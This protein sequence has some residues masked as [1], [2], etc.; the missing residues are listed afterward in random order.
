[1]LDSAK[2]RILISCHYGDDVNL[3]E[4]NNTRISGGQNG[5]SSETTLATPHA[6]ESSRHLYHREYS[7]SSANWIRPLNCFSYF[8][9]ERLAINRARSLAG[10]ADYGGRLRGMTAEIRGPLRIGFAIPTFISR[11]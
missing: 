1:L 10:V 8:P 4:S 7:Q 2:S 5:S 3:R 6:T 11:P 9:H